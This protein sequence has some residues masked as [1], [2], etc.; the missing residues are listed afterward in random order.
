MSRFHLEL[1]ICTVIGDSR[2]T[3]GGRDGYRGNT[4]ETGI[5][6]AVTP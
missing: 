3:R 2:I 1:E 5:S 6:L 4:V